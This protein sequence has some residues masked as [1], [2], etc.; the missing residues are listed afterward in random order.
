MWSILNGSGFGSVKTSLSNNI[1]QMQQKDWDEAEEKDGIPS[2]IDF[3][4]GVIFIKDKNT[5]FIYTK[6]KDDNIIK[7]G[8]DKGIEQV[9][10]VYK[11]TEK[12]AIYLLIQ[13][14][15]QFK[16]GYYGV[17]LDGSIKPLSNRTDKIL[18][19]WEATRLFKDTDTILIKCP[20]STAVSFNGVPLAKDEYY[21]MRY[22]ISTFAGQEL[23]NAEIA[24]MELIGKG[25]DRLNLYNFTS[26]DYLK[27]IPNP[28][29]GQIETIYLNDGTIDLWVFSNRVESG[30]KS[31]GATKGSWV[32]KEDLTRLFY[33]FRQEIHQFNTNPYPLKDSDI[34]NSRGIEVKDGIITFTQDVE[35]EFNFTDNWGGA[36]KD[37]YIRFVVGDGSI[38]AYRDA[39][40]NPNLT[41]D[42]VDTLFYRELPAPNPGSN[43]VVWNSKGA[44]E[45]NFKAFFKAGT[46]AK[47][48][49]NA[50]TW[51]GDWAN[52]SVDIHALLLHTHNNK[53]VL[54]SFREENNSLYYKQLELGSIT[55][56]EEAIISSTSVNTKTRRM[57]IPRKLNN[58][59]LKKLVLQIGDRRET[60]GLLFKRNMYLSVYDLFDNWENG[61][62][63]LGTT[64]PAEDSNAK[65]YWYG[66]D[67][68]DDGVYISFNIVDKHG[69]KFNT[70]GRVVRV[71]AYY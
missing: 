47:L 49:H 33:T 24:K 35:Y 55:E 46:T 52:A 61:G 31:N 4:D 14:E 25:R 37:A 12:G 53:S 5:G 13:D 60:D 20:T 62:R 57:Y 21:I 17:G 16:K 39:M 26:P 7:A 11:M 23:N 15:K 56:P 10:S 66:T 41:Q 68:I 44:L 40:D 8:V 69:N 45:W 6:D 22:P 1:T 54:D 34:A 65:Y 27:Y 38:Q 43:S 71:K 36:N 59:P 28:Q 58:K 9:D 42:E 64:S 67:M 19:K 18:A 48:E 30:I 50:Y 51:A 29:N 3:K 70:Y 32:H 63:L 2:A